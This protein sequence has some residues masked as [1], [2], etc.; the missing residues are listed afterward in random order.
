MDHNFWPGNKFRRRRRGRHPR[1]FVLVDVLV[2]VL[3]VAFVLA[4]LV[5]NLTFLLQGTRLNNGMHQAKV[6]AINE[7]ERLRD[8]QLNNAFTSVVSG[9]FT[10]Q[11]PPVVQDVFPGAVGET[12]VCP[13]NPVTGGC[14]GGDPNIQLVT[15]TVRLDATRAYRFVSIFTNW[16]GGRL[17]A[18]TQYLSTPYME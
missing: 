4:S 6:A 8:Q 5:W 18:S 13:Y 16:M 11:L 7:M 14:G 9:N 3:L 10:A 15:V 12:T 2:T 17:V 1:A